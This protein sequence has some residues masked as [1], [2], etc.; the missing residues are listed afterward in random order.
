MKVIRAGI[1]KVT[2]EWKKLFVCDGCGAVLEVEEADLKVRNL[3]VPFAGQTWEPSLYFVCPQC[4]RVN[5]VTNGVPSDMQKRLFREV[6]TG[7]S[8]KDE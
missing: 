8:G 1:A 7:K 4:K 2:Q 6:R 5:D 3:A